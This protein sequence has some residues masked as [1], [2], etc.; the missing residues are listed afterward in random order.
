MDSRKWQVVLL[1][2]GYKKFISRL[3]FRAGGDEGVSSSFTPKLIAMLQKRHCL[4]LAFVSLFVSVNAQTVWN[5]PTITI[6]KAANADY[7]LAANQDR[8]MPSTWITRKSTQGIFNIA[9]ETTYAKTVN[10]HDSSPANT[11]WASGTLANY[12][13]LSYTDWET[14]AKDPTVP[15]NIINKPAV[16]HLISEN[17]YIGITF[18][19]W[20]VGTLGGGAFSYQRTTLSTPTP[21]KLASFTATK[22]SNAVVLN[23]RTATEE[24]TSSFTLERSDDGKVFSSI[25]TVPAAGNSVA[26][27]QYAFTDAVPLPLNFYRLRTNDLD[28]AVSYSFVVAYRT[29]KTQLLEIFPNPVSSLL[30]VQTKSTSATE[31]QI[32][33]ATGRVVRNL[34]LPQGENA[35]T[36]DLANLTPGIYYLKAGSESKAFVK[37]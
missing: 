9:S 33:D 15:A 16:L 5:G 37:K 4:L 21:V 3:H 24:N 36:V 10:G 22:K 32:V 23:W 2:D 12:N 34:L 29:A 28:G 25:G 1:N 14:W 18:L 17:I 20:G 11:E 6:T 8:I 31:A 7:T 19:S 35:V 27:K 30:Y 13:T 26:E